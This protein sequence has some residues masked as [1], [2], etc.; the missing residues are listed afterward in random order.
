[1]PSPMIR[2]GARRLAMFLLALACVAA[3][4]E[5]YKALGPERGGEILGQPVLPRTGDRA[6]PHTWDMVDRLFDP[7]VRGRDTPI[8]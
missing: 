2:R 6:M 7:E 5:L 3:L 1:M 4:W 8:W